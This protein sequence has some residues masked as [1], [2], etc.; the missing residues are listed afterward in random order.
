MYSWTLG[1]ARYKQTGV[2]DQH[3]RAGDVAG[4]SFTARQVSSAC[5]RGGQRDEARIA[6]L[7]DDVFQDWLAVTYTRYSVA[8]GPQ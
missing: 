6:L 5:H 3:H 4:H 2:I 7:Y 8:V 1:K